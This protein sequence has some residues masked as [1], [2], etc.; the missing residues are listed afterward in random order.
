MHDPEPFS[1]FSCLLPV[2]VSD[3][4]ADCTITMSDS[5]LVALMMGKMNPQ[6][7]SMMVLICLYSGVG[8][9]PLLYHSPQ[10]VVSAE[11]ADPPNSVFP[12]RFI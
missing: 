12:E 1:L 6:L 2:P 11:R 5:D 9:W 10:Q 4:K 8:G 7:V 3:K